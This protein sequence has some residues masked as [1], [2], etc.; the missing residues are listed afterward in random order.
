MNYEK[1][2]NINIYPI[3]SAEKQRVGNDLSLAYN[4]KVQRL[5]YFNEQDG[6]LNVYFCKDA[7]GKNC[8]RFSYISAKDPKK[9]Y[10]ISIDENG[11]AKISSDKD[12]AIPRK[13]NDIIDSYNDPA[14][15]EKIG[16]DKAR[17]IPK[18]KKKS[19]IER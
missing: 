15:R 17:N 18:E 4:N 10:D 13:L 19:G 2:R 5:K 14:L 11:K 6:Q 9:E 16:V 1:P 7:N 3:F 8:E 12:I